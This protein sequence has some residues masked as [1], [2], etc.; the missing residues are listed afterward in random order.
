VYLSPDILRMQGEHG[1]VYAEREFM[2]PLCRS[3]ANTLVPLSPLTTAGVEGRAPATPATP[4]T[5]SARAARTSA[6]AGSSMIKLAAFGPGWVAGGARGA[7]GAEAA[8]EQGASDGG[9]LSALRARLYSGEM[10][11]KGLKVCGDSLV[12]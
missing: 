10:S 3:L 11:V 4:A 6:P 2:C 12:H 7:G 1:A 8:V 9:Q 5:G